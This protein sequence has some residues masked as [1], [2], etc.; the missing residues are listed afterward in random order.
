MEKIDY[1][2][3]YLLKDSGRENFDYSNMD[4]IS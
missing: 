2:I 3:E 4:K 1:L